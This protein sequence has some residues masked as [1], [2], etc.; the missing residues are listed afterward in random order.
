LAVGGTLR[1]IDARIHTPNSSSTS[2]YFTFDV[3]P[4]KRFIKVFQSDIRCKANMREFGDHAE[5]ADRPEKL[6]LA[7]RRAVASV[8]TARI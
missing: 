5:F 1:A 3:S 2:D 6:K 4:L 7:L 8:L